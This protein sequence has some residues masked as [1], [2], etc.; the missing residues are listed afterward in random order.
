MI[1]WTNAHRRLVFRK[2]DLSFLDIT[3][4]M[5]TSPQF[6]HK[7]RVSMPD[8][9]DQVACGFQ[10]HPL[11]REDEVD[12]NEHHPRKHRP[13]GVGAPQPMA[14][15][16]RRVLRGC[17]S[18]PYVA[19]NRLNSVISSLTRAGMPIA[20]PTPDVR[21]CG[22]FASSREKFLRA[23]AGEMFGYT[24]GYRPINAQRFIFLASRCSRI[25]GRACNSIFLR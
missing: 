15:A 19:S 24:H 20:R 1:I 2:E 5:A 4:S 14:A 3:C 22:Y 16:P 6:V 7:L 9:S 17:L 13:H 25:C 21:M 18:Y 10:P 8:F 23:L 11:A 12:G